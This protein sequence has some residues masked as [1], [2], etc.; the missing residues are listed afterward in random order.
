MFILADDLSGAADCATGAARAGLTSVVAFGGAEGVEAQ[1]LAVDADCRYLPAARARAI[2]A[3]LWRSGAA[4]G[5]LFYKKIDSTLR[6]NF[7]TEMTALTGAG[8]AVVAPAFPATGRTTRDAR[9]LVGGVPLERNETWADERMTGEADIAAMLRDAG[10]AACSLPLPIVRGGLRAELQRQV[11]AARVQAVVCDAETDDDLAV[12]ADASVG[13]PVYWV[14]SAGLASHLP[15]AAGIRGQGRPPDVAVD[16]PILVVVGSPSSVSRAQVLALESG[17]GLA[18][19]VA[20]SQVLRAG[21]RDPGWRALQASLRE[22]LAARRDV[23]IRTGLDGARDLAQGHVLC[24]LLAELLAP[25]A[26][27]IGALVVTG[28][29]TARAVLVALGVHG[30]QV[31]REIEPGVALSVALGPRPIAVVTKAG[32]F[33][34]PA[35]LLA[36]CTELARIRDPGP[37]A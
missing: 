15:R 12:I 2:N 36:S 22:A 25:V 9:V 8:L 3:A 31:L 23:M 26:G 33:G 11:T 16:G 4:A 19:L 21:G 14:G 6:G 20:P 1:V 18:S 35:A 7:A 34:S 5:R 37:G 32:A 28:G 30:L 24:E 10:L 13:L 27:G 29:E 17:S